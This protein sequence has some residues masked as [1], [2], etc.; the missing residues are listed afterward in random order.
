MLH[1]LIQ[2]YS[3][4]GFIGQSFCLEKSQSEKTLEIMGLKENVLIADYVYQFLARV[5]IEKS[6]KTKGSRLS[7]Q[8]GILEGFKSKLSS[9]LQNLETKGLVAVALSPQ[10]KNYAATI[11]P[12][13]RSR[14]I[15]SGE[16]IRNSENFRTGFEQGKE[17]QIHQPV[18]KQTQPTSLLALLSNSRSH[19]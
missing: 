19:D 10:L 15:G 6:K 3:V 16:N 1:F 8:S 18:E 5:M 9:N 17:I 7:F 4:F 14:S 12:N 13:L 11:H 2:Y